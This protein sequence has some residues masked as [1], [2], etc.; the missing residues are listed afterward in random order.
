[1]SQVFFRTTPYFLS[2]ALAQS[3]SS[4]GLSN[5]RILTLL[6]STPRTG[7]GQSREKLQLMTDMG[8]NYEHISNGSM[9]TTELTDWLIEN[10]QKIFR[11]L[12]AA[13]I[14]N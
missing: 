2:V 7:Q 6:T 4:L 1:M 8:F 11:C 9:V 3:E 5:T 14:Y 13:N 12:L 10:P